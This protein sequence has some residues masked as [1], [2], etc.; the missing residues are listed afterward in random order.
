MSCER[1]MKRTSKLITARLQYPGKDRMHV[2]ILRGV[3][4]WAAKASQQH[5]PSG[6]PSH[7]G[8]LYAFRRDLE[9]RGQMRANRFRYRNNNTGWRHRTPGKPRPAFEALLAEVRTWC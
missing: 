7:L 4:R 2:R 5:L 9:W 6:E 8:R 3:H 1:A